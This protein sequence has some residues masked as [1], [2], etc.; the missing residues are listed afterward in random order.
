MPYLD[1]K[2]QKAMLFA[3]RWARAS[4]TKDPPTKVPLIGPN[5][6]R[7]A[8]PEYT[9]RIFGPKSPNKLHFLLK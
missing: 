8:E 4:E 2:V 6:N 3:K 7:N 9:V 5:S 1:V